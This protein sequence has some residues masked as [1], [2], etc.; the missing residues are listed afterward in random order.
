[1]VSLEILN[2]VLPY[3]SLAL[4]RGQSST[5]AQMDN[6]IIFFFFFVAYFLPQWRVL[7]FTLQL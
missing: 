3:A 1:M 6:T 7:Q 5:R 2:C 4:G